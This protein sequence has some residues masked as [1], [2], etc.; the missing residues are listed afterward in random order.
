MRI[1]SPENRLGV[2]ATL[3]WAGF[4]SCALLCPVSLAYNRTTEAGEAAIDGMHW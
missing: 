2:L 3:R 4:I 1:Y